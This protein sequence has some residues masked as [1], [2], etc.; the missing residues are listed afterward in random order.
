[1]VILSVRNNHYHHHTTTVSLQFKSLLGN[2]G[3]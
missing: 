1:V 2:L 3:G